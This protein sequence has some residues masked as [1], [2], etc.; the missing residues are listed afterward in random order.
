MIGPD[1]NVYLATGD[2]RSP[3]SVAQNVKGGPPADGTSGILRITQ[4][5]RAVKD[6][7]LGDSH[8]LDKYYAYGIRNSYGMDFDPVT[9]KLW[10]TENGYLFG[11]E[12][13][14]VKP[15]FNSGWAKV[16][17]IWKIDKLDEDNK[18]ALYH[19]EI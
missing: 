19:G 10:D 12:I 1:D 18:D 15:G 14:M 11:D 8:P 17:G 13:N 9:G 4:E 5:G 6:G 3:N 7:I 16:Q 2:L